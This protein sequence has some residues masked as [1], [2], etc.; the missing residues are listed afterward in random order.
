[1]VWER[2][3]RDF[4][5]DMRFEA[6]LDSHG[7]K[8][9]NTVE[10]VAIGK[11]DGGHLELRCALDKRFRL[12]GSGEKTEGAGGVQFNVLVAVSHK[13]RLVIKGFQAPL[14]LRAVVYEQAGDRRTAICLGQ[15]V[16]LFRIPAVG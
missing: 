11:S 8:A 9:G 15:H 3:D 1:M 7:V 16:P 5:A 10:A 14:V 2:A 4:R 13:K 12:R 6:R